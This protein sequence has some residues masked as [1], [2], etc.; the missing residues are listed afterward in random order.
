MMS[1]CVI[2]GL[3][4]FRAYPADPEMKGPACGCG[5]IVECRGPWDTGV[6]Q[7]HPLAPIG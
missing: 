5:V 6:W 1:S 4:L 7:R 3:T 2:G